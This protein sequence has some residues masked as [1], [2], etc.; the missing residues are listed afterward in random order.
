MPPIH[1]VM[2]RKKIGHEAI[3]T[4]LQ[5]VQPRKSTPHRPVERNGLTTCR[6]HLQQHGNKQHQWQHHRSMTV[7]QHDQ[8]VAEHSQ[9]QD[10]SHTILIHFPQIAGM[11]LTNTL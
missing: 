6:Q 9:Q 8:Y 2:V 10:S 3:T 1:A 7:W 5:Q 4:T 11:L